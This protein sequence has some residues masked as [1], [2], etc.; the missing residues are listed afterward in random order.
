MET[1]N[2][3]QKQILEGF[4]DIFTRVASKEYQKR[5]WISGR[6]PEVDDFDDVVN[7]FFIECDPILEN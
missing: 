4:I 2:E 5:I 3:E 6:G 7:D 1:S